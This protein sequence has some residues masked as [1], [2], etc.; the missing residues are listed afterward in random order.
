MTTGK[1]KVS[2]LCHNREKKFY[3]RLAWGMFH[4]IYHMYSD[5][6]NKEETNADLLLT[7]MADHKYMNKVSKT[8]ENS[9]DNHQNEFT[10][11][12]RTISP[13]DLH[14][15]Q[16]ISTQVWNCDEIRFD[17]NGKWHKFVCTYKFFQGGIMWK[18]KTG[19]HTIFWCN[20]LVFTRS[21]RELFM[22]P[23]FFHQANDSIATSH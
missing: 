16:P 21:D 18:V 23:V 1:I 9:R 22:P 8:T 13:P 20:L 7:R 4:K 12:L 17:P 10:F 14:K 15:I 2:G 3:P 5:I 6:N 11:H 19:Y